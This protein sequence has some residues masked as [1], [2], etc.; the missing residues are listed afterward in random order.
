M[1]IVQ[2]LNCFINCKVPKVNCSNH[3][4]YVNNFR[5]YYLKLSITYIFRTQCFLKIIH[6]FIHFIILAKI[7]DVY[8]NSKKR[9]K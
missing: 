9:K 2:I 5:R 8:N 4:V 1:Y 3:T 7:R 6:D